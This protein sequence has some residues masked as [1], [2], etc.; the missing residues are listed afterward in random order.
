MGDKPP[1]PVLW[2]SSVGGVSTAG[3]RSAIIIAGFTENEEAR[4]QG[5]V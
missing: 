1:E 4:R 2:S 3:S 5:L